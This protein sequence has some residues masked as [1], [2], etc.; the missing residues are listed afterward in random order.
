[1]I[2]RFVS[3]FVACVKSHHARPSVSRDT[4]QHAN[5][6]FRLY[7]TFYREYKYQLIFNCIM[8]HGLICLTKP[9]YTCIIHPEMVTGHRC[10]WSPTW[11]RG[12]QCKSCFK[13]DYQSEMTKKGHLSCSQTIVLKPNHDINQI[14]LICTQ[15]IVL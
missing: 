4:A 1:M 3:L 10:R 6:I 14:G 7:H 8:N 15:E 11:T 12:I 2:R 13:A 9:T 5:I